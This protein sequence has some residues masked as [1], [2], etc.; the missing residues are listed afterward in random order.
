VAALPASGQEPAPAQTTSPAIA[1]RPAPGAPDGRLDGEENA[2]TMKSVTSLYVHW[3]TADTIKQF[4]RA[5]LPRASKGDME[6]K[7]PA[8]LLAA[9]EQ[10]STFRRLQVWYALLYVVVEGYQELKDNDADVDALLSDEEMVD[11]MRRFRNAIFHPQENPLSDKL[12]GFL[13]RPESED[14]PRKLNAAFK[15]YFEKRIDVQGYVENW[16]QAAKAS[17]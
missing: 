14:W 15:R 8:N 3:C 6:S 10:F 5:P 4:I 1:D 7:M 16:I 17:D 2:V 9:I 12:L 13:A 11:A